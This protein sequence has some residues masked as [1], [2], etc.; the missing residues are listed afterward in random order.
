MG[1]IK[2]C[3]PSRI[4]EDHPGGKFSYTA[5]V[6]FFE[7]AGLPAIDMSFESLS[8]L[9]DSKNAVLYAA[10]KRA[11]EKNI[12]R[13]VCH[14]SFYMPSPRDALLMAKYSLELRSNID[15]AALMNI[16]LAVIHPIAWYSSEVK[17]GDW[18]R[19]NMAFLSP[20]VE[21]ARAK[22]IKLCIENMPSDREAPENHLYGSC[23]LN[24]SSLA[25]KLGAGICWDTGHANISGYRQSEQMQILKGKIDVLHVHDNGGKG[26]KDSHM[27]PFDG[28]VDWEDVAFGMRCSGFEGI[29]DVEVTAWALSG[30]D[31]TRRELGG[32]V[33]RR[34]QRL[35]SMAEQINI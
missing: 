1:K 31:R 16:P 17:Y 2:I 11:R 15:M 24:I 13:P 4:Y 8:R 21:Y 34:A 23:A 25:E 7:K 19:A 22:G 20:L 6:D 26:T 32:N 5:M 10:A 33:L 27:L 30:D 29:L 3:A 18:V 12:E 35:I 9:D 14:L 28:N